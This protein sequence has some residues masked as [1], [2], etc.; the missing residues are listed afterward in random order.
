MDFTSFCYILIMHPPKQMNMCKQNRNKCLY[1]VERGIMGKSDYLKFLNHI[2]PIECVC[3]CVCEVSFTYLRVFIC[4]KKMMCNVFFLFNA[5]FNNISV[6][7]WRYV[8]LVEETGLPGENHRPVASH[9]QTLNWRTY[10]KSANTFLLK[11][12]SY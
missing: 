2:S 12:S 5:I 7:S 8:L 1:Y 3:V 9:W 4:E 10:T 11:F 6:I